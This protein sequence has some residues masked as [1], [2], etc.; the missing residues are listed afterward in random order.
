MKRSIQILLL[1]L[2]SA[3]FVL[4]FSSYSYAVPA[5]AR[6]T[7]QECSSCHFQH[8]PALNTYGRAFKSSGYTDVGDQPLIEGD[9]GLSIPSTMNLS[10]IVKLRIVKE[11]TEGT[12]T[13]TGSDLFEWQYPDEAALFLGGRISENIGFVLESQLSDPDG[14]VFDSFKMPIG[15]DIAGGRALLIP[16]FTPAH[17]PGFSFE[18]LNTGAVR[19]MRSFEDR[20]SMSAQQ[21]A[22]I[23]A[24]A[25]SGMAAVYSN[26]LF[27]L[28]VAEYA[29]FDPS[30]NPGVDQFGHYLRGA[31]MG[32]IGP[33]DSAIGVQV[34]SGTAKWNGEEVTLI[35]PAGGGTV[36]ESSSVVQNEAKND[37]WAIDAQMQGDVGGMPLGLY[38]AYVKVGTEDWTNS[39]PNDKTG[40]NVTAELGVKPGKVTVGAG[41]RAGD[42]GKATNNDDHATFLGVTYMSKQNVQLQI[43]HTLLGGDSNNAAFKESRSILMLFAAF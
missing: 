5:F 43:N 11:H 36:T 8:M 16:F 15:S 30:T 4:S 40:W 32:D 13:G 12:S 19:N 22:G 33:F 3:G 42:N 26:D 41:F 39:D 37:R 29:P 2:L 18:L 28:N 9:N 1:F 21:W 24:G 20:K 10:L 35:S 38:A 27:F 34:H 23:G 6:Q 14:P 17:G 25:A 31:L 7:G